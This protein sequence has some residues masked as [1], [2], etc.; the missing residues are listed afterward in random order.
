MQQHS[1]QCGVSNVLQREEMGKVIGPYFEKYR[2]QLTVG[3][4]RCWT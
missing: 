2:T 3:W 1:I 4:Q